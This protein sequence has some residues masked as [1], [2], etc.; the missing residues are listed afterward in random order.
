MLLLRAASPGSEAVPVHL[1]AVS[2]AG[3]VELRELSEI[4][5]RI[6]LPVV[7]LNGLSSSRRRIVLQTRF[8]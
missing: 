4:S 8:P 1:L 3:D 2:E 6:R 7:P 5:Q